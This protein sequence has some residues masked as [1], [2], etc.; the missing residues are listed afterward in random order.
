MQ[1]NKTH[2]K[3]VVSKHCENSKKGKLISIYGDQGKL[4]RR[5]KFR[6][7]ETEFVGQHSCWE[8]TL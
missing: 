5:V 3:K 8:K 4:H 7:E 2:A 6:L 1:Q